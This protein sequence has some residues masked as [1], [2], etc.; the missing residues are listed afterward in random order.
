MTPTL[1]DKTFRSNEIDAIR[2]AKLNVV[3][4]HLID[5]EAI[6]TSDAVHALAQLVGSADKI[7]YFIDTETMG[8]KSVTGSGDAV[9]ADAPTLTGIVNVDDLD[10]SGDVTIDGILAVTGAITHGGATVWDSANDGAGS[11][12]DADLLDG[13]QGAYYLPTASYTASDVLAKLLTVDGAGSGLDADRLDGQEGSYYLPAADYTASDILSKIITVDGASSGL[14][15]D[16][17]DGQQGST[18]AQLSGAAFTGAVSFSANITVGGNLLANAATSS[19]F[20]SAH[21]ISRAVA[22]GGFVLSIDEGNFYSAVFYGVSA[23]GYNTA[24]AAMW[25]GKNSSTGRSINAG[26]TINASGADYAEY[27]TK[28]DECGVIAAGEVCGVTPDGKLT[29]R[30]ADAIAFVVKSTDPAYVGGDTWGSEVQ[31]G[32]RP[33]EP[34]LDLPEYEGQEK[35]KARTAHDKKV[36]AAKAAHQKVMR[37]YE[38]ARNEWDARYEQAR[39]KVD[40]IAFCGQVPLK[41]NGLFMAG[42]YAVAVRNGGG[43]KAVAVPESEITFE[44]YR[45]RLGRVW[46]RLDDGRAWID[47]QHG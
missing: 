27:M 43:I 44:Q 21:R 41:I 3:L 46:G 17:L 10:A 13:Q 15:A 45:R 39:A 35:P 33:Q 5:A 4:W 29:K 20:G 1:E 31:I 2:S 42:D 11:G 26:G 18:F 16:L 37:S 32:A 22:E 40:R 14:D 24:A 12:L 28:A 23:S 6:T 8:L 34:V 9:L 7:P 30:Y 36:A 47:V 38:V 19:G 25:V